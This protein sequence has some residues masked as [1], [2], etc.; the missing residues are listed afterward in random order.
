MNNSGNH[1]PGSQQKRNPHE[2]DACFGKVVE[3][4][5]RA[6]LGRI[7]K[8]PGDGFLSPEKHVK[9]TKMTIMVPQGDTG[10]FVAWQDAAV[11]STK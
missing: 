8:M 5:E 10:N 7:T 4:F 1:G 6:V 9:I 2:A 3:G 11:L